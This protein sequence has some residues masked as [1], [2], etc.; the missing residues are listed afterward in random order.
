MRKIII[1]LILALFLISVNAQWG[2]L[3]IN[4]HIIAENPEGLVVKVTMQRTVGGQTTT[5]SMNTVANGAGDYLIEWANSQNKYS[6]G[7]VFTVN[8]VGCSNPK[9]SQIMTYTGQPEI[10]MTFDLFDVDIPTTITTTTTIIESCPDCDI[11]ESCDSCC[12]EVTTTTLNCPTTTACQTCEECDECIKPAWYGTIEFFITLIIAFGG[13]IGIKIGVDKY[14][15]LSIKVTQ[16]K[17][18]NYDTYHSIYTVHTK[19][20]HPKGCIY[21]IYEGGK[22]IRCG[23]K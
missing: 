3:P 16:H 17:H 9:C 18:A 12:P 5:E 15:K 8:I 2:P 21:P 10:F 4:G 19:E 23:D 14:G 6:N 1:P 7:D 11:C 22:F 20:P 13:G